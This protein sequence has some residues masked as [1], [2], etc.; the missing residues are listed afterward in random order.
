M[1]SMLY[2]KHAFNGSDE[3]VFERWA[4]TPTWQYF[5]GMDYLENPSPCDATLI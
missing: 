2:L 1:V 3:G 5:F 4:E